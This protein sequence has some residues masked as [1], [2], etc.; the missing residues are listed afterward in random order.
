MRI[1][2]DVYD[3]SGNRLGAGPVTSV[4][5]ANF[6]RALDGAGSFSLRCVGTDPRALELMTNERR[7]KVWLE[8]TGGRRLA[9][10]GIIRKRDITESPNGV[11]LRIDGPDILDEL[12]RRSVL[13]ARIY[14]QQTVS[15]VASSLIGLVPGWSVSVDASISA[16]VIDARYDGVSV[17]KAFQ[18]LASR[19]GYH[20]RAS[21]NASKTLEIGPFGDATGLRVMKVE[22]ITQ[23]TLAN[24]ALLMVQRINQ[25]EDSEDLCNW[26]LPMGA[27]EGTA[28]L[29][30]KDSDRTSPYTIQTTTGPDGTTLY[31]LS[32]STSITAYGEC[33]KVG[34]FKEIAPLSNSET[35][36]K[37]AANA[38][39]DA[40]VEYL[41]R[42]KDPQE[43]FALTVKNVKDT[44]EPGDQVHINY[45][46]QV[47]TSDGLVD[48]FA[49]RGDYWVLR[50]NETVG[51][52][53]SAVDLEVSNVD[54]Y[55][56]DIAEVLIGSLE[57]IEL[58]NLKPAIS[59]STRSYVYDREI[60]TG[61]FTA[62]VPI[63]FTDATLELQRVRLRIKTSPFRATAKSAQSTTSAG[64]AHNH[65]W[66]SIPSAPPS[67]A[68]WANRIFSFTDGVT[69]YF[70]QALSSAPLP[71]STQQLLG[72]NE[73][74]AHTH[75]IPS[76]NLTFGITDDSDYPDTITVEV[77][78]V[79][80]TNLLFGD[81]T[82]DDSGVGLDAV[83]DSGELTNLLINETGG[84]RQVH[85][86]E[87]FCA[88]GQGRVEVTVEVFETS[89]AIK[90][91]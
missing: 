2:V 66:A 45:K 39:Y 7:V 11:A 70:F 87:I 67:T 90:L 12:K 57:A 6:V 73:N 17:L 69:I 81:T 1:E 35:D 20:L 13:L 83:A 44:I 22:T 55:Q 80:R 4:M 32:D 19:Y 38:L 60:S 43:V 42:H 5:S 71:G 61:G 29:T 16:D 8:D 68:G 9:G 10:E 86:I 50:V 30:L 63:E 62:V 56:K 64:S 89:Q 18:D 14:N 27:G 26:I 59:S 31:Y 65:S 15:T 82:L 88:G 91:S 47:Q 37:N 78:G 3:A 79:D 34:Q 85:E 53:S 76:A 54:R 23:E 74:P 84:L 36:I 72:I 46:A 49:V 51:L 25:G 52:D 28:A 58:R 24:P 21:Q 48:Y 33:R 75:T 77:N 41:T 40:A